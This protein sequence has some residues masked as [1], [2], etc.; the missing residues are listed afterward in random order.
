VLFEPNLVRLAILACAIKQSSEK[1]F[2]APAE[3]FHDFVH[4]RN[5]LE[6][7]KGLMNFVAD[8]LCHP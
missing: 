4:R 7:L 2:L 8:I 3:S 6:I 1:Y 5:K